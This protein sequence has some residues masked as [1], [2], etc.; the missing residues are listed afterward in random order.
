MIKKF[1][2]KAFKSVVN[3]VKK[4]VKAVAPI[5][6]AVA[7]PFAAPY[8]AG[9][10]SL[11]SAFGATIGTAIAGAGLGAASAALQ[12]QNIGRGALFGGISSGLGA[13]TGTVGKGSVGDNFIRNTFG[14]GPAAGLDATGAAAN[15]VGLGSQTIGEGIGG[16]AYGPSTSLD[17]FS[18]GVTATGDGFALAGAAPAAEGFTNYALTAPSTLGTSATGAFA[19]AAVGAPLASGAGLSLPGAGGQAITGASGSFID[20][21]KSVP[22]TIANRV[23]DPKF[24]ADL[25]LRAGSQLLGGV[26]AG[27]GLSEEEQAILNQQTEELKQLKDTNFALFQ[28]KLN[29][30]RNLIGEARY[31]DPEYMGLQSARQQQLAGARAKSAGLRGLN[32]E[33][34]QSEERRYDLATARDTGTAYDQG[35]GTGINSRLKTIEAGI[36]AYPND[37]KGTDGYAALLQSYGVAEAREERERNKFGGFFGDLF[38]LNSANKKAE[39]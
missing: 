3:V 38:G 37:L 25:T 18:G 4:V 10:L 11:T 21:V 39:V 1:I 19:P 36:N 35:Y 16:A 27:D 23:S 28:E 7:I 8:V 30:A 22:S 2:K 32:D 31:F 34:R 15:A 14:I 33:R 9:A 20:A 24:L 5:A 17:A 26:F 29:N 6:L 12:G 13:Y